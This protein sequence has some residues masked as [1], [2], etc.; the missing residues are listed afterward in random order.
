MF[1]IGNCVP[2]L[3]AHGV[4]DKL[5][6]EGF[7]IESIKADDKKDGTRSAREAGVKQFPT[8]L[9]VRD[10]GSQYK[11]LVVWSGIEF[12]ESKIRSEFSKAEKN[13]LPPAPKTAVRSEESKAESEAK[14]RERRL[15]KIDNTQ[16]GQ[17]STEPAE[18]ESPGVGNGDISPLIGGSSPVPEKSDTG[19]DPGGLSPQVP[20]KPKWRRETGPGSSPSAPGTTDTETGLIDKIAAPL[21][22]R[23]DK[24]IGS[25]EQEAKEKLDTLTTDLSAKAEHIAKEKIDEM[26]P[27]IMTTVNAFLWGVVW[28]AAILIVIVWYG[29]YWMVRAVG[30]CASCVSAVA[31]H[32]PRIKIEL[33]GNSEKRA[34]SDTRRADGD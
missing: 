18:S 13:T 2:C 15:P 19:P 21:T 6:K 29:F 7:P 33:A 11:G 24:L 32:L 3:E 34:S 16:G 27:G 17:E 25:L 23:L 26:K 31:K 5:I 1:T 28:R 9:L 8:F 30:L 14:K 22:Q 12:L 20:T 4:V 10:T